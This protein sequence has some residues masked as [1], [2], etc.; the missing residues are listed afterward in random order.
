MK[1]SEKFSKNTRLLHVVQVSQQKNDATNLDVTDF[2][3]YLFA[4]LLYRPND[5]RG[6]MFT[7]DSDLTDVSL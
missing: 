5:P 6:C 7:C 1:Q 2:K 3:H 4:N